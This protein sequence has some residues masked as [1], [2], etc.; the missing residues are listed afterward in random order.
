MA[1]RFSVQLYSTRRDSVVLPSSR[2]IGGAAELKPAF[3]PL[4]R[5]AWSSLNMFLFPV[6]NLGFYEILGF[7]RTWRWRR[8]LGHCVQ[9]P[10]AQLPVSCG[11]RGPF[12]LFHF[13][14][15]VNIPA[16]NREATYFYNR[17]IGTDW[18]VAGR[19]FSTWLYSGD[20]K[21][22]GN[23]QIERDLSLKREKILMTRKKMKGG[24]PGPGQ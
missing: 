5:S 12:A 3:S 16:G 8:R 7:P 14:V 6:K 4:F 20:P 2:I 17:R 24:A 11:G 9:C 21:F 1:R 13:C 22:L 10:V 19:Y 15:R 18:R 23:S